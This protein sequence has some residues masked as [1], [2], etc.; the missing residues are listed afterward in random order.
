MAII[1]N[2]FV[3]HHFKLIFYLFCLRVCFFIIS[4]FKEKKAKFFVFVVCV[5]HYFANNISA[6][7]AATTKNK[8]S[9]PVEA[10][11]YECMYVAVTIPNQL[12]VVAGSIKWQ[13]M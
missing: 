10:N 1:C 13:F 7:A 9:P 12:V 8:L 11:L 3:L 6:T 4:I 2:L 5:Q